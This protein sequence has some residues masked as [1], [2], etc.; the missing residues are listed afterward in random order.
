[1]VNKK[2]ILKALNRTRLLSRAMLLELAG[3]F[4]IKGLTGKAKDGIMTG[5][6]SDTKGSLNRSENQPGPR[7]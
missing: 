4:E 5:Q 2:K 1:M 7:N 6:M 3:A